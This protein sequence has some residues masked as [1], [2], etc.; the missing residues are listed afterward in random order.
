MY[1]NM[2]PISS[3][4]CTSK[5]PMYCTRE[6]LAR[7]YKESKSQF[8]AQTLINSP[9]LNIIDNENWAFDPASMTIWNDR[10]WKGFYPAD[11]DFTN[12]IL[13]YGFGFYKRFWPDKDD[14]GQIRSQK[15]KG[16]THPFNTSI[17]AANQ[18]TD[19]DLPERGKA[20]YIKYS[21]FPFNNFDDL[22]KIVDKDTVLGE[23]FVSMRSPGRGIPT[24]H[25]VLSRR[26]STDFMTQADCRYIFQFKAKDVA[27]EDVLGEWDLK[28]VSNAAHSPPIL[29]VKFFRQGNHLDASFILCGNLPQ[30]SQARA[31][32]QKLAQ[33][34]HLPEKIDSGLIR[35]AGRDLLLG[36]LQEPKNPLFEAM[37]GSRGFV[38]N[39]KEGL[40]LPY[41]LKRVT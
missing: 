15:V 28:L 13:M 27:G 18:A 20:V 26:Y 36:I 9:H 24:F 12:I 11:Y 30:G 33:S 16:E 4:P 41:V 34:L 14:K 1:I 17:H 35:A 40:L 37:L 8:P 22:L 5:N 31:L 23:A 10:Y 38:T 21:D 3:L 32:S 39:D 25:F 19:I 29:R 6:G 7:L 2:N